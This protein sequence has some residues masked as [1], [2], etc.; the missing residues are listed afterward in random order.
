MDFDFYV[1]MQ[2]FRK[3]QG[4]E[5]AANL[6]DFLA[7]K[8]FES[9]LLKHLQKSF[10]T[11]LD[12][13]E[14]SPAAIEVFTPLYELIE[15]CEDDD[16]IIT[17]DW[18]NVT[19]RLETLLKIERQPLQLQKFKA[20]PI[21]SFDPEFDVDYS[22][23]RKRNRKDKDQ[24]EMAKL[25][26]EYKKEF[27]GAMKELRKDNA[28]IAQEQAKKRKERDVDYNSKIKAIYGQIGNEGSEF[29]KAMAHA[30]KVRKKN[31]T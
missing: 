16:K 19:D 1:L 10:M 7:G 4:G 17:S 20:Q 21:A 24:Q 26:H 25:K 5:T 22:L 27:K 9:S 15:A 8:G 13:W 6:D 30:K 3:V 31:R 11:I 18:N 14:S 23:D 29:D 2:D 28:F 12:L